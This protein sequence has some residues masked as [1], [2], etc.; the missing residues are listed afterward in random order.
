MLSTWQNIQISRLAICNLFQKKYILHANLIHRYVTIVC[1]ARNF[2]PIRIFLSRMTVHGKGFPFLIRVVIA[3]QK[4]T[5]V[6]ALKLGK[7]GRQN[8]TRSI[9]CF[10]SLVSKR[11]WNMQ[12]KSAVVWL[13]IIDVIAR[14]RCITLA[15]GRQTRGSCLQNCHNFWNDL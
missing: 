14:S 12:W 4:E 5:E 3:C 6:L 10:Y 8:F 9:K 2:S 1:R 11:R 7:G 15:V 13:L